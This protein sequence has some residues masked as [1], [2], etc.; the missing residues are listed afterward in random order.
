MRLIDADKLKAHMHDICMGIMSGINSY[1]EPLKA[2]DNA[3]TVDIVRCE[4]WIPCSERL[5][6]N[7]EIMLITTKSKK[8]NLSI[9]R[10]YYLEKTKS[11]HGTGTMAEVIA[12][13]PLPEP[14]SGADMRGGGD[15]DQ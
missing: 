1:N 8:G 11:W 4:Q 3:P 2:I 14:Y 6:E 7:E 9:N 10:A 5:P 12:W 15:N 13:M